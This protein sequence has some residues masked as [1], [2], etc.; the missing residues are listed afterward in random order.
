METTSDKPLKIERYFC[1]KNLLNLRRAFPSWVVDGEY[2]AEKDKYSLHDGW[3][4]H[5]NLDQILT[6]GRFD[7]KYSENYPYRHAQYKYTFSASCYD[8]LM[9][10]IDPLLFWY[11]EAD[12]TLYVFIVKKFEFSR[13]EDKIVVHNLHEC[14]HSLRDW[15][16]V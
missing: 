6:M 14:I 16:M 7:F 3:L 10:S 1:R 13:D 2:T 9:E 8:S 15:P 5:W 12:E 4:L 11:S